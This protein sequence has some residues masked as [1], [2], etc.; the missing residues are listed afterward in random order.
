MDANFPADERDLA[1]QSQLSDEQ[2]EAACRQ[3][4]NAWKASR[5]WAERP[6]IEQFFVGS[7][8][9]ERSALLCELVML[10]LEYQVRRGGLKPERGDYQ[11]RFPDN[12][13]AVARAF[14]WLAQAEDSLPPGKPFETNRQ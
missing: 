14:A 12:P 13:G 11:S 4:E 2:L 9:S 10:D 3:F 6:S 7:T 5:S 8:A 1:T